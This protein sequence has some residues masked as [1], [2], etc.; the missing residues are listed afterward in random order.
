MGSIGIDWWDQP[1]TERL[2]AVPNDGGEFRELAEAER[3]EERFDPLLVV[4]GP[5][6]SGPTPGFL[7]DFA[8]ADVFRG[9]DGGVVIRD[10]EDEFV[11]E[12]EH[13]HVR[14]AFIECAV[15]RRVGLGGEDDGRAG[16][17]DD[18]GGAMIGEGGF[19]AG[20]DF[21]SFVGEQHDE[22]RRVALLG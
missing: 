12:V 5:L 17:A 9:D 19:R 18:S 13:E 6:S 2:F 15:D 21:L 8:L 14:V 10:R 7:D 4:V 3:L 20:N 16:F 11:A 1:F 22:I